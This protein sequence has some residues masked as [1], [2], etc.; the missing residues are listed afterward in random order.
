M[1]IL[2]TGAT[3]LIGS[4]LCQRLN[5]KHQITALV[6]D[7]NKAQMQLPANVKVVQDL[8]VFTD[9]NNFD[10]VIN[11]AG[12]PIFARTW[13]ASQKK[14]L[15]ESRIFLTSQLVK[16]IN[17]SNSPPEVFISAS[18]TGYYGDCGDKLLTEQ[19]PSGDSFT[20]KLC[21]KWEQTAQQAHTRTCLL[22]TGMVLDKQ[23]GAFAKMFKLYRYGLGGKLGQ[24]TQYWSWI[25]LPDAVSAI[26]FLLEQ[27]QCQ[28]AF[29]LT[30]PTPV[31]NAN[32]NHQL[33]RYLKVPT[34]APVPCWLLHL[35]L[36]ERA[37]LLLDSQ[38]VIPEKLI[39]SGFRFQCNN[40]QD[41]LDSL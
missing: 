28:G 12:E 5:E 24:G 21:N 2:I 38:A 26:I 29:N 34:F 20:A 22:R 25:G 1:E 37:R 23:Q 15:Q 30:S 9:F 10:A 40:L 19:F 17:Q 16:Y 27:H 3:G 33:G 31:T 11:L 35:V 4:T 13:T 6:R 32:F 7:V 8:S 36:G 39:Q 14:R 41:F 18:A